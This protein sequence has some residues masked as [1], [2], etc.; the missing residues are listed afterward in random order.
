MP[1]N[2][3]FQEKPGVLATHWKVFS[4]RGSR[5]KKGEALPEM[6]AEWK[7]ARMK[8]E[9]L[10]AYT[11]IC[12]FPENGYL[13]PTYPFVMAVTMHFSLLGHPAFPLAPTGGVHARNRIL[14]RRPINANEVFDLWC[15]VGPSRVVKQ[16]LEFD[17]LTRADIGGAA[18]WECVSTY[19]VRGSRFGE[20]G[21][22]PAD[23]KFEELDG[24]NIETGWNVPY[25]MGRRYAKI[26]GDFNPIHL[27]KYTAKLFGFPTDIV[28]GMWSLGK[29]AAQLHVPDP[30]APLRLDAAFKGPVF[31]GSNVTLKAQS[32][33]TGHRFDLFCGDNPRP[34]ING[35]YRNTT[36]EDRLLP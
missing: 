23:A 29:C 28:H 21:P 12:G 3:V 26:T 18:M 1:I 24:A 5:L 4:K 27:H 2:L 6:T 16:G 15:A 22:A 8:S 9:H 25:G 17:M 31:M 14:Q 19:L 7:S 36:A 30:A 33:E 13:P 35:A 20:P 11:A 34:V 32:S 10:A